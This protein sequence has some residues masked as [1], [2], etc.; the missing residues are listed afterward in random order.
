[1]APKKALE[2][3]LYCEAVLQTQSILNKA[4]KRSVWDVSSVG[5]AADF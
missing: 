1:M 5:R 3:K 4:V 2:T